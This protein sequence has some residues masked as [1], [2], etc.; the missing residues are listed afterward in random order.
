MGVHTQ[1]W[2][3][4]IDSRLTFTADLIGDK[5]SKN[6]IDIQALLRGLDTLAIFSFLFHKG[7][8]LCDFMFAI[9]H[10]KFL[11]KRVYSKKKAFSPLHL[12]PRGEN[13]ISIYS[14]RKAFAP[15]RSKPERGLL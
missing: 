3:E 12:L 5:C 15:K 9:L 13:L 10:T 4:C 2:K 11:V 1:A 8:N 14:K 7:D 6:V